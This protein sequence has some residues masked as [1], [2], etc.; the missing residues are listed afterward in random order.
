MKISITAELIKQTAIKK[1]NDK[2]SKYAFNIQHYLKVSTKI[3]KKSIPKLFKCVNINRDTLTILY[4]L[5]T[6]MPFYNNILPNHVRNQ[7][8]EN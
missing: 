2:L 1:N 3:P 5:M 7:Y 8:S 6:N 4:D